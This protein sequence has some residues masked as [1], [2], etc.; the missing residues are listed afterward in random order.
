LVDNGLEALQLL[1]AQANGSDGPP[2]DLVLMDVHMPTMD[3]VA[4]TEAIRALPAPAGQVCILALTA[5]VFADTRDR[6]LAAG[7]AEVVTK[8]LS[9][10]ALRAVL[11][12]HFGDGVGTE[13]LPALEPEAG[14]AVLLDRHTLL[15]VR[16]LMGEGG[17]MR[18]YVGFFVQAEDAARR[19]RESMRD[20]DFEALRRCAHSI[21]G[22]A[23]S[24][25][26]L[27]LAEAANQ[28]DRD[29]STMAAAQ[30]AL[31]VQRF[32]ELTDATRALCRGEGLLD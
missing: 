10:D 17:V 3:G 25:G 24:L 30:L 22:T 11:A 2:L 32:E 5:D 19:L 20:A 4:A 23:Q 29:T 1:Q 28:L 26:L 21:K 13:T 14:A 6:C 18:L 15:G 9:R 31:A 12:R 27:A 16:D 8:P 7:A